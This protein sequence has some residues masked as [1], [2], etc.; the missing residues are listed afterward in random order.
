MIEQCSLM[1]PLPFVL[2]KSGHMDFLVSCLQWIEREMTNQENR[3]ID[4]RYLHLS[5]GISS[6]WEF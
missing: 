5:F 3:K 2:M 1:H 6:I 4:S